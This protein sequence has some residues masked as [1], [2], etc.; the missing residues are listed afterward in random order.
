M[1]RYKAVLIDPYRMV[2]E[3]VILEVRGENYCEDYFNQIAK[4]IGTDN[5]G[6]VQVDRHTT[7]WCDDF[8]LFQPW[9]LQR[10]FRVP[11]YALP[12]AGKH[13]LTGLVWKMNGEGFEEDHPGDIRHT[14]AQVY[15]SLR[16]V[17]PRDVV[18]PAISMNGA[19]LPG[20][21]ANKDGNWDFDHQP[22]WSSLESAING[23]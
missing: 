14:A 23:G 7:S 2:V 21:N 1:N 20:Q 6:Y 15:A 9:A 13:L 17:D 10:F 5:R 8:G 16:W 11:W 19:V 22:H 3:D 18:V 4:F 12:L